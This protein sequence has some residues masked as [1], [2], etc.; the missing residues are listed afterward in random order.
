M[1]Y[2]PRGDVISSPA[3]RARSAFNAMFAGGGYTGARSDRRALKDWRVAAGSADNVSIPDLPTLRA[4]SQ[5]LLRNEPLAVGARN[6]STNDTIG[7]GLQVHPA[8]DQD[9]L[10][11]TEDQA[12]AWERQAARIW[13]AWAGSPA[14]DLSERIDFYT[15]QGLLDKAEFG[16][17]DVFVL[18]RYFPRPGDVLALKLQ[19]IEADRVT[20]PNFTFDTERLAGGIEIDADGRP[21][22]AH[23]LD[24]NPFDTFGLAAR[25]WTA[26]PFFGAETGERQLLQQYDPE[27][28]GQ[29]RGVPKLAPVIE[30]L[31]QLGRYTEAELMAAVISSFFTVFIKTEAAQGLADLGP[32]SE[33]ES[34]LP[35]AKDAEYRLG[36]GA[37]IDLL[38]GE[39]IEIANP[40]RPN[41]AFDPFIMA[42]ARQIGAAIDQPYERLVKQF[43]ASYS[44]SRAALLEAWRSVVTRRSRR[45][46]QLCQPVYEWAIAEAIAR[47]LLSAPGFFDNPLRRR[48]W[49]HAMWTGPAMGQIN[50]LDEINAAE[51]RVALT[52]TNRAQETAELT[53]GNW[54]RKF[55][56]LVKERRMLEEAGLL[57][58]A[59]AGQG[60]GQPAAAKPTAPE[61]GDTER[62]DQQT[63]DQEQADDAVPAGEEA[64]A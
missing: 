31:K 57:V 64:I 1:L 62:G 54:E 53:G 10:G 18:R 60:G 58:Q 5:D 30:M 15:M 9:L 4:R 45:V 20:N 24:R 29:S 36:T 21:I 2:G 19:V 40:A 12:T 27:R 35:M 42:L 23:V 38:K 8:I 22:R 11:L 44:A 55:P 37:I 59:P 32:V 43:T 49:C 25:R 34:P 48:A 63:G 26:V 46:R 7:T 41:Q 28:V 17:G 39:E 16:D 61:T 47:G 14:A 51:K 13:E 33:T 3:T 52:V 6:T 56:Q 50:P